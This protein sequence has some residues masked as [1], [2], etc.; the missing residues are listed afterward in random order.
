MATRTLTVASSGYYGNSYWTDISNS[1]L[2]ANEYITSVKV[3]VP[4]SIW[5]PTHS[6]TWM[7]VDLYASGVSE[8]DVGSIFA[9]GVS[10]PDDE[11]IRYSWELEAP[12]TYTFTKTAGSAFKGKKLCVHVWFSSDGATF[13]APLQITVNTAIDSYNVWVNNSTGGTV[14]SSA[15]IAAP[16]TTVTL[17]RSASTGYQ[18]SAWNP[19]PTSLSIN[20]SGQF[21]MPSTNVT[22]SPTWTKINYAITKGVSPSGSG[23]FS[24]PS[25]ATYNSTV[26]LSPSP[27]SGWQF[28]HWWLSSGTVSNNKFTMPASAVTVIAYFV[29]SEHT[30]I[31]TDPALSISQNNKIIVATMGGYATDNYGE[32]VSY[33]LRK[34][35][36][37]VAAFA[38]NK[39]M[40]KLS[41]EDSGK[42]SVYEVVAVSSLEAAGASDTFTATFPVSE[43]AGYFDG[44]TIQKCITYYF[45][46]SNWIEVEA[47]YFD[48]TSFN[49]VATS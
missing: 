13:T 28:D 38:V 22:I 5:F 48:G 44:T 27:N 33:I 21:T 3:G 2:G 26:T 17:T 10:S 47:K 12:A 40:F 42:E 9:E 49:D 7:M 24:G 25:T 31:W 16:G 37:D 34:D 14:T 1:T 36:V 23:L 39:A 35:G 15:S 8:V 41:D 18:F 4:Q 30:L 29:R 32:D 11:H 19:V 43:Q 6:G 46:G 20:A 45:D